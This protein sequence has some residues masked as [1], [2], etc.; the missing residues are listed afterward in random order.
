[1]PASQWRVTFMR[2]SAIVTAAVSM[3]LW[4]VAA[5]ATDLGD[6]FQLHAYGT[7]GVVHSNQDQADF[8][9]SFSQQPQGAGFT[10]SWAYDVDSKAAIQ[11]DAKITDKL[12]AVVQLISENDYNSSWTG[13][14]NPRFRPSLEWAN[15]KYAITDEWTARV[16]R[17][18]LPINMMSEYRNVGY[19]LPFIRPPQEIYGPVP[20]TNIDGGE[21]S[22]AKRLGQA[23]NTVVVGIGDTS[24]RGAIGA[25]QSNLY[26]IADTIESGALTVRAT[27][28]HNQVKGATGFGTLFTGFADAAAS[29]PG[30]EA[31]A[32]AARYMDGRYNFSYWGNIE[33]YDLGATY[34]PGNWFVMTEVHR[35]TS[36][37]LVGKANAG[38]VTA[39]YRTHGFTPYAT[40]ARLV[41]VHQ[42]YPSIPLGGL[43]PPLAGY[44]AVLNGL[45]AS[46]NSG[47]E[48]QRTL[49]AGLRWD[50]M[51]NL[52]LK[53][54]YDNVRLD[55]GSTGL[56][57]NEQPGFRLGSTASVFSL[58]VDFVF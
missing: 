19:S 45:V 42:S 54:Q 16:G 36:R 28:L 1:M 23:T 10:H 48:G 2:K 17:M 38:F 18:V 32:S 20:F 5:Q 4:G 7:A 26:F 9:S 22:Y 14:P 44:G 52:D 31:A 47:N 15:V 55:A 3:A 53:V 50:F 37:G 21:V 8:V 40:Y 46:F 56:F 49:T 41:S 57:V 11:L 25:I 39:G 27:Y 58:A 43:P 29:F 30:G 35:Y 12:S 13:K 34:D 33:H 51:K 6:I 24:T